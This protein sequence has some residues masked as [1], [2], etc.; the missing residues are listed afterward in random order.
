MSRKQY[1]K[2][3]NKTALRWIMKKSK[4][5]FISIILLVF[6]YTAL[7]VLGIYVA[8]CS[9]YV[10]NAATGHDPTYADNRMDGVLFYGIIFALIIVAEIIISVMQRIFV[11]RISAKLEISYKT[12]LFTE[13]IQKE[14]SDITKYHS[15]ELLNRLTSDIST[16]TG[17]I[18]TIIPSLTFMIVK[19]VGVFIVLMQISIPF[20]LI[21]LVA[22]AIS[23]FVA[24]LYKNKMKYL[25]KR[26]QETDGKVRSFLQE[27]MASLL[28]IK[29]FEAEDKVAENAVDLQNDNYIIK[30]KRNTISVISSS[31]F[32][33]VFMIG[34]AFALIWGA[35][36]IVQGNITYGVL[37]EVISLITQIQGPISGLT[38]IFP[39]YFAATASA[40]RIM[41]IENL[42]NEKKINDNNL[43]VKKTYDNLVS[44]DFENITF[45]YDRDVILDKTSLSINKGDFVAIMGITGIGKSTLMKL[46]MSVF[47]ID[48]GSIYM[49]LNNGEK[50]YVDKNLRR[51]FAYVPQGN[52]LLSGTIRENLTFVAPNATDEDI[53]RCLDLAC[54]D[55]MNDLPK[56]LETRL[57]ERGVGLSEGQIQRLAIARALLTEAPILLLDEC[58]SALDEE[59][60]KKLLT[61]L[62]MLKNKT[63]I[64]ITHK[65]AALSICNK[66]VII[67][68]KKIVV[69][70]T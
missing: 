47:P 43:D 14:F 18:V 32:S 67:R 1:I 22:G 10:V 7:A 56:G 58:T 20:T 23:M 2:K 40:E 11:F 3:L 53:Y 64:I 38:G 4:S 9:K 37:T 8:V 57:G 50:M 54:A 16:I 44:I 42:P 52:F 19:L 24:S 45:S 51:M 29:S 26:A 33:F 46:L 68:D 65:K 39:T 6:L 31:A 41:E 55:F 25:H 70:E 61:N 34:Y 66:E 17:A 60:E 28:V 48:G 59:T 36:N 62:K 63:C 49:T 5:Q 35:Y 15:G 21:F 69:K 12:E 13:I 27:I 30:R